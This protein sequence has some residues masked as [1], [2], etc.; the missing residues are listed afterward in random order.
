MNSAQRITVQFKPTLAIPVSLLCVGIL[1]SIDD[2][3]LKTACTINAFLKEK[4]FFYL[5]KE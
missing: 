4:A 2:P 1:I 5:L 3:S